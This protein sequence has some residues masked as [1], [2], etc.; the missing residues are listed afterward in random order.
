MADN[1]DKIQRLHDLLP[2][3]FN[4][5][6]NPNWKAVLEA[7]GGVDQQTADLVAEVRKQFFVKT[8]SRPYLD[9]LAANNK[10]AR[11]H[12]VGMD[13]TSFRE[14]IPV[15][16]YKPKQVK[17]IIDQLLDIFFF[18][19]ST[20]AF[21]TS[22]SSQP[23]S[24]QDG[25]E[26]E[27]L[28][29]ES[30]S[31]RIK[32]SASDFT[33]IASASA[34][35]VVAAINRQSKYSYA[36]S[37]YDSISKQTYIKLFTNTI[38]SKGSL[39]ISGGR[40][41][42]SFKFNGFI[43]SAG[44]G[45]NT[46][47]VVSKIGDVTSFQHTGGTAPGLDKLQVGD[48][49]ISNLVNNQGSF[50]ITNID[51]SNNT[52]SFVNLFGTPGTYTQT[53]V[54]DTKFLRPDKYVAY[55]NGR[56][57]M[58]WETAPGE[59]V[60]EMPTSPPVVKRSLKG[61]WHMNGSLSNMSNRDSN[62]ALSVQ[63]ASGFPE[64]GSF[65]IEQ[66][67]E[68]L[69]RYLTP[70]E[71]TVSS[72]KHNSRLQFSNTKYEYA[73]RVSLTTT[74]DT[75]VGSNQITNLASVAGLAIGNDIK[76]AGVP[77]WAKVTSISGNTANIS[78]KATATA[79][80]VAVK[81]LGNQLTGI[82]PNLPAAASLNEFTLTSLSRTSNIGTGTTSSAHTYVAGDIVIIGGSSGIAVGTTT[83]DTT[84]A[85]NQLTNLASVSG[86]A[87]GV[88]VTGTGIPA[89]TTV[90]DLVGNTA[91]LSTNAT[92]T[93]SGVSVTFSENL[94]GPQVLLTASGSTFTFMQLGTNG[95]ATT[96]GSA[97]MEK[98]GLANSGSRIIVTDA[99]RNTVSRITGAYVWDLSAPFVLSSKTAT[100]NDEIKAGKI[101]RL[102]GTS[103]NE[104]SPTG[105]F[106]VFDYGLNTQEG[107]VRYLYKPTDSTIALDPSYVFQHKHAAGSAIVAIKSK[108][109]HTMSG[110]AD[111]Y[112][113]YVT[114]PSDARFI[115]EDLIRSVKSAGIFVNFLIRYP[116]QL[117]ATLDVYQSGVDPG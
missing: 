99:V 94:N 72:Y 60:V 17:L 33:S 43:D 22:Q 6:N 117:Y 7:I 26:L 34:D 112:P 14:Y 106:L 74:G 66:V 90:I 91:T 30:Y 21:V 88:L 114:N 13:D 107:P 69:S 102:L 96:P 54:T 85:S 52:I 65:L 8:A 53:A 93:A 62:T 103:S 109:P 105:G 100:I 89:G 12:L 15:L 36:T 25:W 1:K 59:I 68:I 73:S 110:K 57:A 97:R 75:V 27:Y 92:A 51:I 42:I 41:N 76:M 47:W 40:A 20:T 80:G 111:E 115:L 87:P 108:G 58:T 28:V 4:T 19:E 82:T 50:T 23:F 10:I 44:N 3:H 95:T 67:E 49:I 116:E 16:S 84:F 31:E 81:F 79:T 18:K 101:V 24:I 35:E 38:G 32:F 55:T 61:S 48:I 77:G 86:V 63:D 70:T 37:Y 71:N 98:S 64:S 2:S 78:V 56:R 11:P 29:D 39:R 113:P 104:I 5:Q 46:Q 9:R 83:G 45:S